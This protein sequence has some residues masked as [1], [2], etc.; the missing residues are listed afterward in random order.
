MIGFSTLIWE[1]FP[2]RVFHVLFWLLSECYVL[3]CF[4]CVILLFHLFIESLKMLKQKKKNVD[5]VTWRIALASFIIS[6]CGTS[7]S[8]D[9][10]KHPHFNQ[11]SL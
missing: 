6:E 9:S 4:S 7:G 5:R 3:F 11:G 8:F 10:A 2:L 1:T